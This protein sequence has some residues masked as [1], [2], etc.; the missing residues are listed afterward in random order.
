MSAHE[1]NG[2]G[3]TSDSF[4]GLRNVSTDQVDP[5]PQNPRLIFPEEEIQALAE[6]I[7][8]EG[9]LVPIVVF[10]NEKDRYTLIDGERRFKCARLLGLDSVPAVVTAPKS[11]RQNLVQMFNIHLVRE[12]WRDMPTAWALGRL[13]DALNDER[14]ADN[15]VGD[16]E[17]SKLTGLSKER[18]QRLRHALELPE[19]YQKYIHEGTIPLNWFWELKKNVVD[20]LSKRRPTVFGEYG[21]EAVQKAFVEKR[22][23]SVITDTVSLRNVS[24]IIKYAAKDAEN[25]D[26]DT[27]F[28]DETIRSLIDDEEVSIADAYED[29]VQI[30]VEVDKLARRTENMSKSFRRLIQKVRSSDEKAQVVEIGNAFITELRAILND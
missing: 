4:Q 3:G 28:L 6:S 25:S 7:D 30:M 12:P 17:L 2:I 20:P 21:E 14:G 13:T 10:R 5:N 16:S 11:P 15:P 29:T 27:S 26:N 1:E 9:I 23:N 18:I 22:L 24:P 8:L 19:E